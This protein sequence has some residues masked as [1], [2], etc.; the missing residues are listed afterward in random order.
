V[1]AGGPAVTDSLGQAWQADTGFNTGTAASFGAIAI[2]NTVDDVLYQ[3][4]RWDPAALPELQYSFTVPNG[5]YLVRLHFADNYTGTHAVGARVF[6][7]TIEGQ[8]AFNDLD[9]FQAVGPHAALIRVATVTVA[10]GQIN[11]QFVHQV[12]M[13]LI[14][15]IEIIGQ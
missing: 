12:E 5:S 7:V 4:E 13:P 9:V 14:N 10:D 15:A 6:D 3:T 1:N 11:I 8:L 2:G